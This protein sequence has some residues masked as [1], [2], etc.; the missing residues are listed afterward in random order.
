LEYAVINLDSIKGPGDFIEIKIN[1]KQTKGAKAAVIMGKLKRTFNISPA[2]IIPW[3]YAEMMKMYKN[4]RLWHCRPNKAKNTGTLFLLDGASCSGKTTILHNLIR[5]GAA[6]IL[7]RYCTRK[8]RRN[9]KTESEYIF[10]SK[11]KFISLALSGAFIEYRHYLFG[12][13]YGIPWKESMDLLVSGKNILGII[14]LGNVLHVKKILPESV[15]I[16]IDAPIKTIKK[17]LIE[18]GFNKKEQ[19][20]ERLENAKTVE[21]YKKYYDYIINNDDGMLQEAEK[22]IKK[23][24]KQRIKMIK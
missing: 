1:T 23:I 12:M 18:R 14:N 13:S 19:M 10:V 5:D 11:E 24:I 16:L 17:R 2:E 8:P 4:A 22:K 7:P 15:L 6:E 3:S 20:E 9:T 21:A